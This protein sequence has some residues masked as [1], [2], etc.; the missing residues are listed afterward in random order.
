IKG[1]CPCS[2][3]P[4]KSVTPTYSE[5]LS[6]IHKSLILTNVNERL[7][8][9]AI[10]VTVTLLVGFT[11]FGT[12]RDLR[13]VFVIYFGAVPIE[14]RPVIADA[15]FITCFNETELRMLQVQN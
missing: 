15:L 12:L 2:E 9:R 13:I 3:M 14:A 6:L 11:D 7:L 10:I 4:D 1:T 5:A 8:L